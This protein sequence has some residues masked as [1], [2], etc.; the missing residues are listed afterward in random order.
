MAAIKLHTMDP[1]KVSRQIEDF[2]VTQTLKRNKRGAVLGLSGGVDSSL[3]AAAAAHGYARFNKKNMKRPLNLHCYSL[4]TGLNKVED[5]E[6]AHGLY[7][8]LVK[9]HPTAMG[10]F[11]VINIQ[12]SVV[13]IN[14]D[15]VRVY[16]EDLNSFETG[17]MISRTRANLLHTLAAMFNCTVLGTG[18]RDEDFTLGYYTLLGDGAVFSS[19][20]GALPKRLVRELLSWYGYPDLAERVPTAGLESGQTDFGDLGYSYEFAETVTEGILQKMSPEEIRMVVYD[21]GIRDMK[22]YNKEFRDLKF[23]DVSS[24]VEDIINRMGKAKDKAAFIKPIICE[25]SLD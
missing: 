1:K 9:N 23:F 20:I 3:V 10:D 13:G 21:I 2:I 19:P 4:P 15:I 8:S 11:R 14:T 25:V 22:R 5:E 12:N 16:P 6:D 7:R 18:N 24:M 17:N